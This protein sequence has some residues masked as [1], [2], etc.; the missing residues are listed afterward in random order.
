MQTIKTIATLL[1]IAT[2]AFAQTNSIQTDRLFDGKQKTNHTISIDAV[3]DATPQA[4]Y[5]LWTTE[6]GVKKFFAPDA[7]IGATEGS[8]Y[9]II[10][11]PDKDPQGLSGGTKGAR[12]LALDPGKMISF[13]W[14]PFT[15][16]PGFGK[17][18]PPSAPLDVRNASPLPTW[19]E[20]TLEPTSDG[21]QTR[22]HFRHY[23][24]KEGEL[25]DQSFQYFSHAWLLV[26]GNLQKY[27]TENQNASKTKS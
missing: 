10:F 18:G 23:G 6:A 16:D 21:K 26:I 9:T 17:I 14:I 12:I 3:V 15:A 11:S 8:E 7:H 1:F 27:C 2:T 25:W 5:R 24:F 4:V 13:E 19:V 22:L 20:I